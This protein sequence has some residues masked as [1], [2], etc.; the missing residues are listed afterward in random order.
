MTWIRE[1]L[2]K[3]AESVPPYM[4]LIVSAWDMGYNA[5]TWNAPT[6]VV[7]YAPSR[8]VTGMVDVTLALAYFELVAPKLGLG[9][10]WAGLIEGA[11]QA[12]DAVKETVG[13]PG[14]TPH[15]HAMMVGYSKPKY[16]RLPERKAPKITWK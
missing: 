13:L 16:L 8:A 2:S 3:N 10:C 9:T 1:V 4:P 14:G 11:L 12:S 7:A 5:V 6:L 15:H